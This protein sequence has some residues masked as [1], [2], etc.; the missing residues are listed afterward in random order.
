MSAFPELNCYLL[1]GHT[2]T[3]ADAIVEA[4][5]AEALGLGR[6]WLSE[7][8]D[9]KEAGVIC[10]AA[11][12]VTDQLRVATAATNVHTRHPLLLA[13]MCS[14]LAVVLSWAWRAA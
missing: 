10:S 13:S 3:P 6:V 14:S 12:A 2:T 5:Q 4:Q 11:L 7:R 8:F 1:P 9:V